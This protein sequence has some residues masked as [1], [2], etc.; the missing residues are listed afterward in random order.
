MPHTYIKKIKIHYSIYIIILILSISTG[1][2]FLR[3]YQSY[4]SKDSI[5]KYYNHVK[6][7]KELFAVLYSTVDYDT[8]AKSI[9]I[10]LYHGVINESDKSNISVE[11]FKNHMFALKKAGYHTITLQEYYDFIFLGKEIPEKSFLLT[12]DDGRKDS[13]YPVDPILE[14]C[15]YNAV[16]FVIGENLALNSNYYLSKIELKRMINS[17]RWEVQSHTK[18]GQEII[19]ISKDKKKGHF[20]F[21]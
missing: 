8:N 14:N 10:L 21:K 11:N 6:Y 7:K 20:F 5:I 15:N 17:G 2:L 13:Y 18:E 3:K 9:P 12:F 1:S 16:M 19:E 4:F